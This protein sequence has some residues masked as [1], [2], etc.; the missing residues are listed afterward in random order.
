MQTPVIEHAVE[1]LKAQGVAS[2]HALSEALA[3]FDLSQPVYRHELFPGDRLDA[4][5]PIST[6][7]APER[8]HWFGLAVV[9]RDEVAD[10]DANG[11][12]VAG[13][14]PRQFEVVFPFAALAGT[15]AR[16]QADS[17]HLIGASSE[18]MPIYVPGPHADKI[19]P[20]GHA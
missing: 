3:A 17:R 20:I 2:Q 4:L 9:A 16:A 19:R 8:G 13:E 5:S 11:E 18:G 12:A 14:E 7:A 10:G 15:P 6:L 1:L